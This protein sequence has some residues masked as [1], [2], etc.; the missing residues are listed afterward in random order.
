MNEHQGNPAHR[1]HRPEGVDDPTVEAL[2][3]LSKALETTERARGHLYSFHQLTGGAD[4]ELGRAVRLLREAGHAEWAAKAEAEILGRDVIPGHWTFQIIEAYNDTYY[5]PFVELER[6]VVNALA[7]GRD[8]LYEAEMKKA[9]R[10]FPH[11]DH[12][13]RPPVEDS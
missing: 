10:T 2:G 13:D 5:R 7:E 6:G 9:R 1:H 11:H 12:A 4:L 3:S 8:H